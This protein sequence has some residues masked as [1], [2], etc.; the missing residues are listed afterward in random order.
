MPPPETGCL[1]FVPFP[2]VDRIL[3]L[4]LATCHLQLLQRGTERFHP[5]R[6]PV[7]C[8]RSDQNVDQEIQNWVT[9]TVQVVDIPRVLVVIDEE[10]YDNQ[11][12]RHCYYNC[13][14]EEQII[15]NS[16]PFK[17]EFYFHATS[18]PPQEFV[19]FVEVHLQHDIRFS[20]AICGNDD[21]WFQEQGHHT[22]QDHYESHDVV[23]FSEVLGVH[24]DVFSSQSIKVEAQGHVENCNQNSNYRQSITNLPG[25][26]P[27]LLNRTTADQKQE[28]LGK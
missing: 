26:G 14:E 20:L 27:N 12:V 10:V 21:Y 11:D 2:Q 23:L 28:Q 25:F 16:K 7:H 18:P 17:N 22:S 24:F 4:R 13:G 1:N 19:E 3:V 9:R 8:R 6:N 15:H 5:K